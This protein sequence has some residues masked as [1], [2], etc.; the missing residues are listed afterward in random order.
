MNL[1]INQELFTRDGRKIGNCFVVSLYEAGVQIKKQDG[2]TVSLS[3][4][5][6]KELFFEDE[7][8]EVKLLNEVIELASESSMSLGYLK[9]LLHQ[10]IKEYV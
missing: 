2:F 5:Q 9:E 3:N 8:I 10:K 4:E 6:I 1:K 7:K